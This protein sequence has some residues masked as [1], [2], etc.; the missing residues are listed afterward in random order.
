MRPTRV[1]LLG[2]VAV[3]VWRLLASRSAV[4]ATHSS[5]PWEP[6]PLRP[7][8][9]V[10]PETVI[11][12]TEPDLGD[13]DWADWAEPIGGEVPPG[14]PVKGKVASGIYHLPGG[15][16]YDRTIPD[17]CYATPEDA[18]SDGLRPAKL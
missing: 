16:S 8:L 5:E 13:A 11:D 18:E 17:R 4:S 12:L 3:G 14:Y 10:V 15:L 2:A 6:E 9:S 7:K 1:V